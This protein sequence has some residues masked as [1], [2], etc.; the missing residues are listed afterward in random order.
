MCKCVNVGFGDYSNMEIIEFNGKRIQVD[1]CLVEEIKG[2]LEIG[3]VT[4][5]SCCGH[6]KGVGNIAV[7][8]KSIKIME[9]L[10]YE[11]F[12]NPCYPDAKEYFKP[13][14]I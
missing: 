14:S 13:K 12:Y 1:S 11:R 9:S 3:V 2:L 7:D 5:A 10:G 6:N 8:E 4:L